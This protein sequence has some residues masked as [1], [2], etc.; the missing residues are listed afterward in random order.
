M[1]QL[2]SYNNEDGIVKKN[3]KLSFIDEREKLPVL[4]QY[5]LKV[6][7]E[8]SL[9]D[10]FSFYQ[11]LYGMKLDS[12]L[13]S[14]CPLKK[15][16]ITLDL[17]MEFNQILTSNND[18]MNFGGVLSIFNSEESSKTIVLQESMRKFM[19]LFEFGEKKEF[20]IEDYII[21]D[22]FSNHP[23]FIGQKESVDARNVVNSIDSNTRI[24]RYHSLEM[25]PKLKKTNK[26]VA[27][28]KIES[29][30]YLAATKH[31]KRVG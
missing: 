3:K 9:Q 1:E 15:G 29:T 5:D 13:S 27:N 21:M 26:K 24:L 4:V 2:I 18:N 30:T 11:S 28:Q 10:I 20:P 14:N 19:S 16:K 12:S 22:R 25:I 6:K 8:T 7:E 17:I 31:K 23:S